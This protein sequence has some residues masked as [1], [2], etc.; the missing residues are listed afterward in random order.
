MKKKPTKVKEDAVSSDPL[1]ELVSGNPEKE[2]PYGFVHFAVAATRWFGTYI[3]AE[4]RT[5]T[6]K[7]YEIQ[8]EGTKVD[9]RDME[10]L[11]EIRETVYCPRE[12]KDFTVAPIGITRL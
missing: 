4:E 8:R 7:R 2:F 1:A 5:V 3:V 10:T 11:L 9:A 12:Q 6:G